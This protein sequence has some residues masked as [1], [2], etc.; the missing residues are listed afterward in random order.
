ME[1]SCNDLE[2]SVT[3]SINSCN[4][5]DSVTNSINSCND[6]EDSVTNSINSCNDQDSVTNSELVTIVIIDT[7]GNIK[8]HKLGFSL[9]GYDNDL[10]HFLGGSI[11][12]IGKVVKE[13]YEYIFVKKYN[14]N[15]SVNNFEVFS[16]LD[17]YFGKC[18]PEYHEENRGPIICIKMN[19]SVQ[20]V[21]FI[22]LNE[23][24]F[25]DYS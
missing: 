14:S 8:L 17:K 19:E 20:P 3:N 15:E 23:L 7:F 22:D 24:E 16:L 12:I 25:Y 13:P 5:Q 2:D 1:N 11:T 9:N 10:A 21:N 4:D 18:Q 6:L